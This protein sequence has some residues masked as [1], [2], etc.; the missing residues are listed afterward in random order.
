MF[1]VNWGKKVGLDSD[2]YM[3]YSKS[4]DLDKKFRELVP[5]ILELRPKDVKGFGIS[6]QTLWNVKQKIKSSQ[7]NRI[8][9]MFMFKMIKSVN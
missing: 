8:S 7:L 1:L 6:R 2:S 9:N 5:R 4:V 3:T